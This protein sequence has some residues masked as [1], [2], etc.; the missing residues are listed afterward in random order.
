MDLARCLAPL[1][2]ALAC[3]LVAQPGAE[4]LRCW[5]CSSS[6]DVRCRDPFNRTHLSDVD[7]ER[8]RAVAG[9][10]DR[11][12]CQKTVTSI[13]GGEQKV[14]RK[15]VFSREAL[16]GRCFDQPQSSDFL[17]VEHCSTCDDA[18]GC[19]AAPG[20]APAA[21]SAAAALA[22]SAAALAAARLLR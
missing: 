2:L 17:T 7:C 19:N 12:Y 16:D 14:L 9:Y 11:A 8:A 22:L 3:L 18:D 15:C 20:P 6:T 21:L 1:L 10:G 13:N 5:V 4:A